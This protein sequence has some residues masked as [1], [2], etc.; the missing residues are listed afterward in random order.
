MKGVIFCLLIARACMGEYF[1]LTIKEFEGRYHKTYDTL[2]EEEA[3]AKNLAAQEA[4]IN[5]QNEKFDAGEANFDEELYEWDDLSDEEFINQYTGV[6]ID[7]EDEERKT[8]PGDLAHITNLHKKYSQE[9]IP[10]FWDSRDPVLTNS[11]KGKCS[12]ATYFI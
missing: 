6:I 7:P 2:E 1:N 8:N 10:E 4:Q 3:A 5:A 11:T 12:I 9:G